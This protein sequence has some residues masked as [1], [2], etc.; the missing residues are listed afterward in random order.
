MKCCN[1]QIEIPPAWKAAITSNQC[2]ACGE[3]IM[4]DSMQELMGEL[5]SALEAMPNDPEGLA[6]W[7]LSHYQLT[8]VGSGEPVQEFYGTKK[9]P[10]K[11][12]GVTNIKIPEN[13]IQTFLKQAGIKKPEK[14]Y[15]SIVA[16]IKNGSFTD[17]TIEIEDPEETVEAQDEESIAYTMQALQAMQPPKTQVQAARPGNFQTP[18]QVDLSKSDITNPALTMDRLQRL[19]KQQAVSYGETVGKIRRSD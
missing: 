5:K 14:D 3:A 16:E 4:N 15:K 12:A 7:L 2:P 9:Q 6:G 19:E 1:C 10:A 8:K 13:R 17:E 11:E 18:S